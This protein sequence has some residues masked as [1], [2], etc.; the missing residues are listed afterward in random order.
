MRVRIQE[1]FEAMLFVAPTLIIIALLVIMPAIQTLLLSFFDEEGRFVGFQNFAYVFL[2]RDTLNLDRF[3]GH[4]PPWGAV[5]HNAVWVLLHLP[6]T[7]MLGMI[8]AVLLKEAKGASFI[9]SSIFLG[10][11]TP[12]IVGGV[13]LRFLF[14]ERA[15][16][17]NAFLRLIGLGEFAKSWMAY[18]DSALLAL[19]LGSV[20]L[21]TG[22]SMVLYSAGLTTIPKEFYEAAD[23]DG[24][25]ALQ[26]FICI[27]IPSLRPVTTAVVA[28]TILW[29][30]KIFD[31]VYTATLGGP[32]GASMVMALQMYFLAFRRL[33]HNLAAVIA[34]FLTAL[35]L[36][37]GIW[38][39]RS[40]RRAEG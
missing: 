3:P 19:I 1:W 21:W 5:P 23:V 20:W 27:T 12:M 28:M 2:S 30:L 33:N 4:S 35:T 26:K 17:I 25:N 10:M 16:V 37:I 8:L 7:V 22:F 34:T 31:I 9:K 40:I 38:F 13:V 18:P 15:G 6:L 24:A 32:G 29:E 11:V 36:I 14:D 39:V